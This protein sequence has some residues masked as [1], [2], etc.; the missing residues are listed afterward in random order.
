MER[1]WS[2]EIDFLSKLIKSGNA[3]LARC[4]G[5][6]RQHQ[7]RGSNS[8]VLR[9][10]RSL[11][12]SA[13]TLVLIHFAHD[14]GFE[15]KMENV[16][17]CFSMIPIILFFPANIVRSKINIAFIALT[18]PCSLRKIIRRGMPNNWCPT[19]PALEVPFIQNAA[20]VEK[21]QL[22]RVPKNI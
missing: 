15:L 13:A 4:M 19:Q 16:E 7:D 21:H 9:V 17:N 20:V 6:S 22:V 3:E 1:R 8:K 18:S 14:S 10:V 2:P 5:V 11:P 12:A